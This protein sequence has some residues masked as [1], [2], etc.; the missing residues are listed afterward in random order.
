MRRDP[1]TGRV[2]IFA[3]TLFFFRVFEDA[4]SPKRDAG[5]G[6]KLAPESFLKIFLGAMS[7][8]KT[9]FVL[10]SPHDIGAAAATE[11][12]KTS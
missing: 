3:D 4:A 11:D 7:I 1:A 6:G 8:R 2:S 5:V 12:R 9:L 10:V